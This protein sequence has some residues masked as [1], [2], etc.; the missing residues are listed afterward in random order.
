[1]FAGSSSRPLATVLAAAVALSFAVGALVISVIG[2]RPA[3]AHAV[4]VKITP[5]AG[6][7]LTTA[8]AQ[9]VVEFN[10]PVSTTFVTVVVTDVAGL[11]VAKGKATVQGTRVT[12]ALTSEMASGQYRI[13]FRVTS[14]DGHPVTGESTF[15]LALAPGA[16]PPTSAGTPPASDAGTVNPTPSTKGPATVAESRPTRFLAPIAGALGLLGIGAGVLLWKRRGS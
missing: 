7:R 5:A 3:S 6:A 14:D 4:L 11:S 1:M 12:Q 2:A 9:V 13:A 16:S 8:P 10:E 15:T